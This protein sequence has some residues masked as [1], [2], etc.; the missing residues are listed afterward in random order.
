LKT[1]GGWSYTK[2]DPTSYVWTSP[3]GYTYLRDH[4]GTR[5]LDTGTDDP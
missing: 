3:H 5:D 2:A 4:H 1:H